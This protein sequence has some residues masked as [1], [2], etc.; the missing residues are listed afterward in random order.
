[1]NLYLVAYCSLQHTCT[2][3]QP[4][5]PA[6]AAAG[7]WRVPLAVQADDLGVPAAPAAQLW[8]PSGKA[9]AAVCT[10]QAPRAH[11]AACTP[12]GTCKACSTRPPASC[13]VTCSSASWCHPCLPSQGF[14]A[15]LQGLVD[16]GLHPAF[17]ALEQDCPPARP[18]P[19]AAPEPSAVCPGPLGAHLWG[20]GLPAGRLLPLCEAV[21]RRRGD[22][23]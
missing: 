4:A 11:A 5:A 22:L 17:A 21:W 6:G 1:M 2:Q 18:K 8:S 10:N 14:W 20:S 19:P 15:T 16:R 3:I 23:L 13:R 12:C 9:P 7:I